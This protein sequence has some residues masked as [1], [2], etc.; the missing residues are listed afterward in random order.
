[1]GQG[2]AGFKTENMINLEKYAVDLID[3][4]EYLHIKFANPDAA[5]RR[6][7]SNGNGALSMPEFLEGA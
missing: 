5:F 7:D 4:G 2:A 1:M 6:F 3:F